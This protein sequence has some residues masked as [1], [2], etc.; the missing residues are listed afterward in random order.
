MDLEEKQKVWD[1]KKDSEI[2]QA[3]FIAHHLSHEVEDTKIRPDK[4]VSTLIQR[5]SDIRFLRRLAARNGYECFVKGGKGYF[6]SPAMNQPPQKLLALQF[7][8]ETNLT[9]LRFRVDGTPP[10]EVEAR[11]VDP[12][13]KKAEQETLTKTTRRKLGRKSLAELRSRLPTG[14]LLLKHEP[15]N[16]ATQMKAR[17]PGA[18]ERADRFVTVEG[19]IDSRAYGGVLRAKRLVTIKGAG[20]QLS[21]LY[22][23]SR[24]RHVFTT[25]GYVQYF[26][27]YRNG[28]G[29]TGE[30]SFAAAAS[31]FAIGAGIGEAVRGVGDLVLPDQQQGASVPT[32]F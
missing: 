1:G 31:P 16:Y 19:E 11:R 15:F 8:E 12:F 30:E 23:V 13:E 5:D 9:E 14:R 6:R 25:D 4:K 3:I 29:L 26:E 20:A 22:Y 17:L 32:G 21:G 7:G 10:S 27:A 18:Y 28:L 24:V 2:A